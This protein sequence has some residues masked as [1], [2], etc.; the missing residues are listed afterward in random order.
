MLE[1]K[2]HMLEMK[3]AELKEV[4]IHV[5]QRNDEVNEKLKVHNARLMKFTALRNL[6]L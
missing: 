2:Q 5:K 1:V 3:Q 6:K 4:I